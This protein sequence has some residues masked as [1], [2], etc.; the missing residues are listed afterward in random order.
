MTRGT[1]SAKNGN[2]MIGPAEA[3]GRAKTKRGFIEEGSNS[4]CLQPLDWIQK[5]E[6]SRKE[7]ND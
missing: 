3:S 6:K 7:G 5:N 1:S 2:N 4:E